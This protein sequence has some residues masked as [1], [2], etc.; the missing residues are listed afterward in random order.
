MDLGEISWTVVMILFVVYAL[1]NFSIA[2]GPADF[3][4]NRETS[5]FFS[6]TDPECIRLKYAVREYLQPS[7][8]AQ[9][10]CGSHPKARLARY[11]RAN[12]ST[13]LGD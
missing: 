6:P 12:R 1:V 5:D 8:C 13:N 11:N 10:T 3:N 7:F 2:L 4:G 9:P